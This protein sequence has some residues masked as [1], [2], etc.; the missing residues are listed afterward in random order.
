[1]A[2]LTKMY[3]VS[4]KLSIIYKVIVPLY[5]A[6]DYLITLS[7]LSMTFYFEGG[8]FWHSFART[9]ARSRNRWGCYAT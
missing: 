1:M 7:T 8:K 9:G 5:S 3:S 6:T 2:V 4:V